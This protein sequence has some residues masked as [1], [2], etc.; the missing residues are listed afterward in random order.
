MVYIETLEGSLILQPTDSPAR[1]L[2][3]YYLMK[4][5]KVHVPE[6]RIVCY[7]QRLMK[8]MVWEVERY[9]FV[10]IGFQ[11]AVLEVLNK[12]YWILRSYT[13]FVTL[14]KV[15]GVNTKE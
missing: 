3:S 14:D 9:L 8:N 10:D 7:N 15:K 4:E 6:T 1:H 13:P 12:P 2:F 5:M 11:R